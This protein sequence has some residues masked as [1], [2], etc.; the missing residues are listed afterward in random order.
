MESEDRAELLGRMFAL[1]TAKFEDAATRAVEGQSA[2]AG[3]PMRKELAAEL[4]S[5]A[6]EAAI[7]TEA[8]AALCDRGRN[9][10]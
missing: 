7:L 8:A 5:A 10:R 6:E 4:R 1:M 2:K 9:G 3:F